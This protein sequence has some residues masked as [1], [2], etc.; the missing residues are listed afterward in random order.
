[1]SV[2]I[3]ECFGFAN[4]FSDLA[5]GTGYGVWDSQSNYGFSTNTRF[6]TGRSLVGT[7]FSGPTLKK[8]G[9]SNQQ[10]VFLGFAHLDNQ[11]FTGNFG[12]SYQLLDGATVQLTICFIEQGAHFDINVYRGDRVNNGSAPLIASFASVGLTS[13]WNQFQIKNVISST[14]GEIHIR[15]NG[16]TVDDFSATGLNNQSSANAYAN[17]VQIADIAGNGNHMFTTDF[18]AWDTTGSAPWN[19][20]VGDF[21]II[22]LM[23]NSDASVQW[24]QNNSG[25][26]TFGSTV[27]GTTT[28][29]PANTI[30]F[31]RTVPTVG[32]LLGSGLTLQLNAS[33]S[34]HVACALY[35]SDGD[36]SN[37]STQ[38]I[39]ANQPGTLLNFTA[40]LTNPGSG[41]N[42]FAWNTSGQFIQ[43]GHTYFLAVWS[44]QPLTVNDQNVNQ[45]GWQLGLTYTG[46][47]PASVQAS[48]SSNAF[49]QPVLFSLYNTLTNS[50]QINDFAE[51]GATTFVSTGVTGQADL[52]GVQQLGFTPSQILGVDQVIM[53]AKSDAGSRGITPQIKSGATT[54]G[55]AQIVPNTTF[56]VSRYQ[57]DVDPN[58]ASGWTLPALNNVQIGQTLSL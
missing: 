39:T 14:V 5:L 36:T 6:G 53:T 26:N 24:A 41:Q 49:H 42:V 20:W 44:D 29:Y 7:G 45:N 28:G 34:G 56:N 32:G 22:P 40:P 43:N 25:G 2:W 18:A 54:S 4:A 23:P 11:S 51:D 3:R 9:F 1:M 27:S 57:Q 50:G 38:P 15:K 30:E 35:D 8:G 13:Q 33:V 17:G 58:T 46:T 55:Y 21:R 47:F 37:V 19:N 52:Y 12:R 31:I 48:G 10:T 16:N